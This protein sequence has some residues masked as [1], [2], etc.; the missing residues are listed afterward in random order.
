MTV[1]NQK[2][3][4]TVFRFT[5][6]SKAPPQIAITEALYQELTAILSTVTSKKLRRLAPCE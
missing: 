3:R 6:T 5:A 4:C 2:F 1:C